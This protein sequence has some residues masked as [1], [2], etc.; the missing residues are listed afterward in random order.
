MISKLYMAP[1]T[2]YLNDRIVEVSRFSITLLEGARGRG[3]SRKTWEQC[4]RDDI[5]LLA[6]FAAKILTCMWLYSYYWLAIRLSNNT[7]KTTLASYQ[8]KN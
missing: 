6:W 1:S 7:Q 2:E 3:R 8:T 4:V 5:K